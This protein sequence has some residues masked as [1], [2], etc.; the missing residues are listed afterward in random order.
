MLVE[1]AEM[2]IK[3]GGEDGFALM[4]AEKGLPLLESN[5]GAKILG[6]GRGVENPDTFM[7]LI[8]WD[9]MDAHIAFTKDEKF[10]VFMALVSPFTKGGNMQ[11][12]NMV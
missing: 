10:R 2:Q 6:F 1:R 12:F 3:D 4:M 11:H 8:E 9:T 7:L 5:K